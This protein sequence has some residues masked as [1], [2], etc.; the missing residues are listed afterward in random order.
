[1][2]AQGLGPD[3]LLSKNPR[4]VYA[5]LTGYGQFGSLS[6]KGGHDIN[7]IGYSG[8]LSQL[9]RKNE[10]PYAPINLI[11]DF[12]GG[13]LMCALA[14]L[15]ALY[16]RDTKTNI[17]KVLDCNMVEGSAYLSSWLWQSRAIPG[18]W[19]GGER[20]ANYLDGGYVAYDTYQTRDGKYMA[21]G[22]LEPKF[23]QEMLKGL[24]LEGQEVTKELLEE[25]F[26]SKTQ[27]EWTKI[28]ENMDAC[29]TPVL[30]MNK[31]HE[32]PH[33]KERGSFKQDKNGYL[34]PTMNWLDNKNIPVEVMPK[35]GQNSKEILESIG[36]SNDE[37]NKLAKE[38][39]IGLTK[40]KSKL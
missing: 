20:G 10:R 15:N 35:I 13:G 1:M 12:A 31:V 9:G 32:H 21:V 17:G 18:L 38:G 25:K 37:V 26:M 4:L 28:F 22:S 8:V 29:V 2:Y 36:Y 7:Y 39:I 34:H 27:D 5:R 3:V 30:D 16:E 24:E 19:D 33:N 6:D 11:A 14:I 40:E 23:H